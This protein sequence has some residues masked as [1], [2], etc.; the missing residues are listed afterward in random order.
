[1][2][3][4]LEFVAFRLDDQRFALPVGVAERFVRAVEV[5]PLPGAPPIALGAIDVGGTVVPV[6]SLRLRFGHPD[7]PVRIT[8]L[9]LIARTPTRPVALVVDEA[10]GVMTVP[11]EAVSAAIAVV[12]GL[13]HVRGVV[14]LDDGLMLIHDLETCLSLDEERAVAHAL[15]QATDSH[16]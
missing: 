15:R 7:R 13:E 8:D 9:F 6:L 1:M 11:P 16:A 14:R 3:G 2:T 5:T 12:P 10:L 4:H